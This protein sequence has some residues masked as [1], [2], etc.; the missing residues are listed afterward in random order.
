MGFGIGNDVAEVLFPRV[1]TPSEDSL[2]DFVFEMCGMEDI[3][4]TNAARMGSPF[5]DKVGI[6]GWV[7]MVYFGSSFLEE[8]VDVFGGDERGFWLV[9]SQ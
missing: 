1:T 7:E 3:T 4:R 8:F 9:G 6:F 5:F 2:N